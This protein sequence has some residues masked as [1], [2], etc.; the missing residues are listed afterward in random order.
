MLKLNRPLAILAL[1]LILVMS[2]CS[3]RGAVSPLP[4]GY[5][6]RWFALEGDSLL[7]S[8]SPFDGSRD[9]LLITH[10][11]K[12]IICMSS[13]H[14]GFLEAL[15][16]DSVAV[17]V[18]GVGYLWGEKVRESAAE[19]GYDASL[20]Y[21]T[22]LKLDPDLVLAYCI[23]ASVPPYVAKLRSLGVRVVI[24]N[25]HLESHPLA[26]AEYL[27]FVGALTGRLTQADSL[28]ATI[29][30]SYLSQIVRTNKPRK[31][32]LNIPYAGMWY[33]PGEDNYMSQLIRDAGGKVLGAQEGLSGSSVIGFE[34]ALA[35]A[36]EADVWLNPG[37]CRTKEQLYGINNVFR[38]FPTEI[39]N[40]NLRTVPS[41][42]NDFWESGVVRPDMVLSDLRAI[43]S[44]TD[45]PLNYHIKLE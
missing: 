19:V 20:D 1:S 10:P 30:Q 39:Y 18:S 7:V 5:G 3:R 11:F 45:V 34:E 16:C 40:N 17:G 31:A 21:E 22:V 43:F 6:A 38:Q 37:G 36:M 27:R 29:K 2:S 24:V 14:V 13:S 8:I 44:G 26:R 4:E 41:G 35:L 23:S 42:G 28:F 9:S 33:V 15:G 25:E 12:R 32:I